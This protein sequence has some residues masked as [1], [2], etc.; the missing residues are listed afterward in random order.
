MFFP[1]AAT[2]FPN[3]G[4]WNP[5][6]PGDQAS[7]MAVDC[8]VVLQN[9]E[10]D[11]SQNQDLRDKKWEKY[12]ILWNN[13][14]WWCTGIEPTMRDFTSRNLYDPARWSKVYGGDQAVVGRWITAMVGRWITCTDTQTL[15]GWSSNKLHARSLHQPV[16]ST[17]IK[18][19]K[20][21]I[22]LKNRVVP[23]SN[24]LS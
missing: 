11:W 22:C 2:Q 16:T 17:I 10:S 15:L 5:E 13:D 18:P 24:R 14:H 3:S 6:Q 1:T 20:M 4:H 7:R 12:G 23:D 19:L 8:R 21:W 9:G